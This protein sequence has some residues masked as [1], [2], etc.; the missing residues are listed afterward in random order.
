MNKTKAYKE[1]I[2]EMFKRVGLVYPNK[3]LTDNPNWYTKYTWT[4]DEENSYKEW[5]KKHLRSVHKLP[6]ISASKETE[7]FLLAYG[8]KTKY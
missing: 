8:W 3:E 7:W 4:M 2:T 6:K 1:C 5:M